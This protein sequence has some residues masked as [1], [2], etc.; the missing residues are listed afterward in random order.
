MAV[1]VLV[2]A[3]ESDLRTKVLVELSEG[4][5]GGYSIQGLSEQLVV[6]PTELEGVPDRFRQGPDATVAICFH[7]D[8]GEALLNLVGAITEWAGGSDRVAIL[9]AAYA[10]IP[11]DLTLNLWKS[12]IAG[13]LTPLAG[14]AMMIGLIVQSLAS[15]GA[16]DNMLEFEVD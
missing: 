6:A 11:D 4:Q 9:P 14:A 16:M 7:P 13:V 1:R 12:Q 15:G 10:F 2:V 3:P 5:L 8:N